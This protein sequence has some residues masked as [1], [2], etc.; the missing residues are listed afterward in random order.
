MQF[1]WIFDFE[2]DYSHSVAIINQ[3]VP[4]ISRKVVIF[5]NFVNSRS[6]ILLATENY[7]SKV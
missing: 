7:F 2:T 5:N 3:N 4:T 6:N 1:W